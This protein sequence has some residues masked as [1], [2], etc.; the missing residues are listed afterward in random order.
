MALDEQFEEF[1]SAYPAARRQRGFMVLQGFIWAVEKAGFD[2]LM[3]ALEQHKAS[4]QWQTP[5]LIPMVK[6]WLEEERW[7]QVLPAPDRPVGRETE[8]AKAKRLG[9]IPRRRRE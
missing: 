7:C 5:S 8:W 1:L 6:K 2:V 9:L 3:E 4:E